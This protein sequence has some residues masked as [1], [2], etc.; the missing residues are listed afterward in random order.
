MIEIKKIVLNLRGEQV[1]LLTKLAESSSEEAEIKEM[2]IKEYQSRGYIPINLASFEDQHEE[3]SVY[4]GT[5]CN[6]LLLAAARMVAEWVGKSCSSSKLSIS[7][8][9]IIAFLVP[10][11]INTRGSGTFVA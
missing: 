8:K 3:Q 10:R 4:F 9:S 6:G 1:E 2:I 5:Y 11:S 7:H